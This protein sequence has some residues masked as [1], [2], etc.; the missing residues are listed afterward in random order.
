M[1][2]IHKVVYLITPPREERD[3][4]FQIPVSAE[5]VAIDWDPK[6][7][8]GIAIWYSFV[9]PLAYPNDLGPMREW[10]VTRRITGQ[11]YSPDLVHL[12]TLVKEGYAWHLFDTID[13]HL[14]WSW[15]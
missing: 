13:T 15:R 5:I 10:K 3:Q 11:A 6:T 9:P 7:S 4:A 8:N 14:R 2:V 1:R 12:K